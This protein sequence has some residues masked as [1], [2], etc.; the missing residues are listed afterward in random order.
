MMWM[1]SLTHAYTILILGCLCFSYLS[2]FHDNKGDILGP[3]IKGLNSL[4]RMPYGCGEQNMINFAPNIYILQYLSATGQA[5]H[6][7]T[8]KATSYM[9][10]GEHLDYWYFSDI[11]D[12]LN[13]FYT[14]D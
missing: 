1:L 3:S 5:D 6:E 2:A 9:I 11:N 8:E 12:E 13:I 4:I 14:S 10:S 7:T